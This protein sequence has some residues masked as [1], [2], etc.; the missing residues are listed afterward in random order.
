MQWWF[1]MKFV[2]TL[3]IEDFDYFD[4]IWETMT[5]SEKSRYWDYDIKFDKKTR[6]KNLELNILK[7]KCFELNVA[8]NWDFLSLNWLCVSRKLN[9][10]NN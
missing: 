2:Q 1:L 10:A 6:C 3:I 8:N 7:I 9:I 4:E 5:K